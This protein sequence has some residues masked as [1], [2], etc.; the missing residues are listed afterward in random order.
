MDVLIALLSL[1]RWQGDRV[2][3]EF[4]AAVEFLGA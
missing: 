2:K 4:S 3:Q 1:H